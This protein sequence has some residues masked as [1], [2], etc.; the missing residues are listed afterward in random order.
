MPLC[1]FKMEF[2]LISLNLGDSHGVF[3]FVFTLG[4]DKI[5]SASTPSA[6]LRHKESESAQQ[7]HCSNRADND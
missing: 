1:V 4:R 6:L 2:A 5:H 3:C 7:P